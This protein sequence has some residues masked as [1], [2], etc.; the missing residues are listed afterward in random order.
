[1]YTKEQQLKTNRVKPKQESTFGKKKYPWNNKGIQKTKVKKSDVIDEDYLKWLGTQ[2]CVI[3][4]MHAERGTGANNIHVHHIYSR[5]KGRNDYKT[6][7]LMGFVHSWGDMCY[8]S[9]TKEDFI[10]K[11]KMMVEDIIEFF[12]DCAENFV[13]EYKKLQNQKK[14]LI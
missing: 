1:M 14:H 9:N 8:H 5:N 11:H 6:V 12:D 3:T 2:K 13:K 10:K 7:P 4:G